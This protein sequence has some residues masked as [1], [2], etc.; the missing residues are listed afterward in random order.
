[1]PKKKNKKDETFSIVMTSLVVLVGSLIM[2]IYFLS[3]LSGVILIGMILYLK[4]NKKKKEDYFNSKGTLN[5]IR[6][7]TP[8]GFEEYIAQLFKLMGYKAEKVGGSYDGGID[9]VAE[10]NGKKHYI[11]CK[12]FINKQVTVHDVRDFYGAITDKL[13]D[14]KA[15]FITTNVYTL[16]AEKFCEDKPIELI[17]GQGLIKL[18]QKNDNIQDQV[19]SL[20]CPDCSGKLVEKSGKYGKFLGCANYPK[21]KFTRNY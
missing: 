18:L 10:K 8:D 13:A 4:F 5:E 3:I 20:E 14:A 1:M 6:N 16:E 15:I 2:K 11:Q 7:L 9:V 12:K 17:D 19:R 21:C